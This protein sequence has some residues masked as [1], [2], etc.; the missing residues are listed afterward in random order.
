LERAS[1][2]IVVGLPFVAQIQPLYLDTGGEAT[3]QGRLK[4][5]TAATIRV[6]DTARL[7]FGSDFNTL[8]EWKGARSTDPI[9]AWHYQG[10]GLYR[11][12]MR[13]Y[14]APIFDRVGSV[15]IQQDLPLPATV[16][17]IIPEVAQGDTS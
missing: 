3:S 1:T 16:L 17:G 10:Y 12:D 15:C 11:G 8:Q 6:S 4:K 14:I 13:A 9:E 5:V 7:K 2:Q